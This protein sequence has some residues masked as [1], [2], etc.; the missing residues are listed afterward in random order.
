MVEML[1]PVWGTISIMVMACW[2]VGTALAVSDSPSIRML[3]GWCTFLLIGTLAWLVGFS[4]DSARPLCW[5]FACSGLWICFRRRQWKAVLGA[6]VI[7]GMVSTLFAMPFLLSDHLA[8]YGGEGV[9]MWGYVNCAEWVRQHPLTVFPTPGVPMRYN[10]VWLVLDIRERPLIYTT[11]ASFGSAAGIT[12]LQSYFALPAAFTAS[13]SLALGLTPRVFGLRRVFVAIP[14]ALVVSFH[15]SVFLHWYIGS[16]S[17]AIVAG[18]VSLSFAAL[19]VSEQ[20]RARVEALSLVL[21]MLVFCSA[22]YAWQFLLVAAF[23]AGIPLV[24]E[25]CRRGRAVAGSGRG[26]GLL[27]PL[28]WGAGVASG[29]TAAGTLLRSETDASWGERTQYIPA[30]ILT[31]FGGASHL[32]WFGHHGLDVWHYV[33]GPNV[34]GWAMATLTVSVCVYLAVVR[35]Q[36]SQDLSLPVALS[37]AAGCV[38]VATASNFALMRVLPIFGPALLF[39]LAVLSSEAPKKW[40]AVGLALLCALP[41]LRSSGEILGHLRHPDYSLFKTEEGDPARFG[42]W[43]LLGYLYLHEESLGFDWKTHPSEFHDI[44]ECFSEEQR[45]RI[46]TQRGVLTPQP[47]NP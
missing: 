24:V 10:W 47:A 8:A 3:G 37:A 29:L 17:G 2:G 41:L 11:L 40:L 20:G 18:C 33:P 6:V 21:L 15:P 35:W 5:V 42:R 4:G 45:T 39:G 30:Q 22:L 31:I 23:T 13:L 28:T 7:G 27:S 16:Y 46:A 25:W 43:H 32:T 44:T 38:Y 9:D 1:L 26:W 34:L 12:P 14:L 36:K 19:L